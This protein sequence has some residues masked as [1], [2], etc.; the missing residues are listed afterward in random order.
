[1]H[2][3]WSFLRALAG[4]RLLRFALLARCSRTSRLPIGATF[5]PGCLLDANHI[6]LDDRV[7][8]LLPICLLE[9][10]MLVHCVEG[11]P[12]EGSGAFER[13]GMLMCKTR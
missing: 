10:P 1:M 2:W 4:Y 8:H 3:I 12:S 6:W 9:P 5:E 7:T 13:F 11:G